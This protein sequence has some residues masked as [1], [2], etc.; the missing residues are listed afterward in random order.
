[1]DVKGYELVW[2]VE[3]V[4]QEWEGTYKF[5]FTNPITSLMIDVFHKTCKV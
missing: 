2:G 1:M 5:K 4:E 3:F